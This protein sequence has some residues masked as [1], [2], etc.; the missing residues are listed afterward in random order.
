MASSKIE[1]LFTTL[2]RDSNAS[3]GFSISGGKG[4]DQFVE[5]DDSVYISKIVE[6]GPA[7]RDGK[8]AVGDRLIQINGVD[9]TD[10]NHS[11]VVELLKGL[12]RFVRIC[13]E[14]RMV[15]GPSSGIGGDSTLNSPASTDGK[16]PKVFGLPRPYTGLYS[17]SSYMANRPS[18]MR[19][20]EPGQYTLNSSTSTASAAS[21]T[22][23]KKSTSSLGSYGRLP[24]VGGILSSEQPAG[25]SMGSR[26]LSTSAAPSAT[27]TL[28]S[29]P[30]DKVRE[31]VAKLPTTP[32]K[33]GTTTE[34]VTKRT[35][36]ETTVKRVTQNQYPTEV[37]VE[38]FSQLFSE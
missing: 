28:A 29:N 2:L 7:N 17:A 32:T 34:T 25:S 22:G 21:D 19:N 1:R 23:G 13:V 6:G 15:S 27:S 36:T 10:A 35:F 8:I 14:R 12:E 31:L 30:D 20:R 3:L 5:G 18:Y 24:G 38:I 11:K 16:S 26:S 4:A 37:S 9:V 33:P